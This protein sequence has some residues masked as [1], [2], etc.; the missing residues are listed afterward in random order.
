MGAHRGALWSRKSLLGRGI[1]TAEVTGTEDRLPCLPSLGKVGQGG[2]GI[3]KETWDGSRGEN[4][5]KSTR[6]RCLFARS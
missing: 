2:V 6:H 5:K 1:M 4:A 3:R